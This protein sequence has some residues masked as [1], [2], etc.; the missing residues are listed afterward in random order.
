MLFYFVILGL[1]EN[2]MNKLKTV[3]LAIGLVI[4]LIVPVH[5]SDVVQ[6]TAM[7]YALIHSQNSLCKDNAQMDKVAKHRRELEKLNKS[8]GNE[9]QRLLWIYSS[10]RMQIRSKFP[11]ESAGPEKVFFCRQMK[12][13]IENSL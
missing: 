5:A 4:G 6:R 1:H 11:Y 13:T 2:K 12:K 3:V 9:W 7:A 10:A 8:G